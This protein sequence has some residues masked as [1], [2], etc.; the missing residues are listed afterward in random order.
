MTTTPPHALVKKRKEVLNK[1]RAVATSPSGKNGAI[2]SSE[3][4]SED[5]HSL[6]L[7]VMGLPVAIKTIHSDILLSISI[8]SLEK[9]QEAVTS[10]NHLCGRVNGSRWERKPMSVYDYL[11]RVRFL[12]RGMGL[13]AVRRGDL[14]TVTLPNSL[15]KISLDFGESY[16]FSEGEYRRIKCIISESPI[17]VASGAR[18]NEIERERTEELISRA[19]LPDRQIYFMEEV[20]LTTFHYP[21]QRRFGWNTLQLVSNWDIPRTS[22]FNV[23]DHIINSF[24]QRFDYS[25][26]RETDTPFENSDRIREIAESQM[27][28]EDRFPNTWRTDASTFTTVTPPP[29]GATVTISGGRSPNYLSTSTLT[30]SQGTYQTIME[31]FAQAEARDRAARELR[32]GD[33]VAGTPR[34]IDFR[35]QAPQRRDR[36]YYRRERF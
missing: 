1:I 17:F 33:I 7:K 2:Y 27:L 35:Q 12:W 34:E 3:V 14:T 13:T 5:P 30:I 31:S 32:F 18:W 26:F 23:S 9:V 19:N 36:P 10:F 8:P 29:V 4:S 6:V 25:R 11:N 20:D 24:Q 28:A 16:S 22:Y 15:S 21:Q